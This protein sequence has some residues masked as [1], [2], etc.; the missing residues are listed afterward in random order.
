MI[1]TRPSI[2]NIKCYAGDALP[3]RFNVTGA[4]Y[5]SHV[6]SGQVRETH[7]G[8]VLAEFVCVPDVTGANVVLTGISTALLAALDNAPPPAYGADFT[9]DVLKFLGVWDVEVESGGVVKTL[10]QGTIEVY[11]QVTREP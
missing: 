1:D 8:E 4:D 10:V 3:L 5:S 6:W 9:S 2:Q 11:A 7:D